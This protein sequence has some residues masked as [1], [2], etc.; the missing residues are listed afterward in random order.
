MKDIFG[1][2][3]LDYHKGNYTEDPVTETNISEEDVLP[4]PHL[5]RSYEEMPPLEQLALQNASGKVL[6]VGCGAGS[7]SLFLEEKGMDVMAIDIS[8]GAVQVTQER[9]VKNV[10]HTPL[11]ELNDET[12]DT[13]LL[14]MNG[15]GIFETVTKVSTYLQHLKTLLKPNGQILVDS[16]DLKY[17]YDT[18]E[19]GG[20]WVP[21]DRYYGELEFMM[22][23]KGEQTQPFDWLYLDEHLFE[24]LASE[25]GF[26]F[27]ILARGEHYDYLARLI[28]AEY[29]HS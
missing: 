16:S 13:I 11:L 17:M 2:A 28:V 12:F 21:A 10:L 5:F 19:E 15:T 8:E 25:S 22:S 20:I 24:K 7:H 4:L 23:Y 27:E 3:L 9:G 18:T 1:K 29:S 14:L 26:Q 6:D